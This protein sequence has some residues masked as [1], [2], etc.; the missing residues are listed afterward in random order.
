MRWFPQPDEYKPTPLE[1]WIGSRLKSAFNGTL[2]KMGIYPV[3][4]MTGPLRQAIE[5]DDAAAV[6]TIVKKCPKAVHAEVDILDGLPLRFALNREKYAAAAAL[7]DMNPAALNDT[8]YFG[9][10]A[11]LDVAEKF[12]GD[13]AKCVRIL[14]DL[15]DCGAKIGDAGDGGKTA[16]HLA[17]WRPTPAVPE[18][19]LS[20]GAEVDTRD[21]EGQTPLMV[22]ACYGNIDTMAL[23]LDR[24]A[25]VNLPDRHGINAA[26]G[27]ILSGRFESALWL[28]QRG[29]K[30]DFS[31]PNLDRELVFA[32]PEKY[33]AFIA[34][35]AGQ[36]AEWEKD[37]R[38]AEIEEAVQDIENGVSKPVAVH[39]LRLKT[40]LGKFR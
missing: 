40:G 35:L 4:A 9:R 10:T 6:K 1:V 26:T 22:A 32:S 8:D 34:A 5:A 11:L 33:P 30:I 15:L 13:D 16:L 19:L 24:G 23:L 21:N 36:R 25:D 18:F 31:A 20:M 39:P 14:R 2:A 38:D 3:S 7:L 27:A 12:T 37:R 28:M 29:A 17:A